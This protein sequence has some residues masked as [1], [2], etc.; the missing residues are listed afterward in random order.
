MSDVFQEVSCPNCLNPIDVREHGQH[1][2]CDA[3]GSQFILRGHLCPNC[4]AYH[5]KED[6]ICGQCSTPLKRVCRKC[7]TSNWAG[8]EYCLNCGTP[9]DILDVIANQSQMSTADRLHRQRLEAR[10]LK[11]QE[12]AAAQKRMEELMAIEEKRQAQ[13]RERLAKQK[14]QERTILMAVGG[15]IAFFLVCLILYAILSSFF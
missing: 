12:E 15:T 10:K 8:D 1:I 9:M 7:H 3:C 4:G 6:A 14:Q 13:L 2:N 11:A 5:T